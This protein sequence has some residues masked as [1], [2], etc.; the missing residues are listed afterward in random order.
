MASDISRLI[1]PGSSV[2]LTTE[3]DSTRAGRAEMRKLCEGLTF[4]DRSAKKICAERLEKDFFSLEGAKFCQGVGRN[5]DFCL[6]AVAN[7]RIDQKILDLCAKV[8]AEETY[9]YSSKSHCVNFFSKNTSSF[10]LAGVDFCLE[11][12]GR[13]FRRSRECLNAIRDRR[14]PH[15]TLGAC[16]GLSPHY[17]QNESFMECVDRVMNEAPVRKDLICGSTRL[18]GPSS[19]E[20]RAPETR[21]DRTGNR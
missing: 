18:P 11:N 15:D 9:H 14:V 2:A 8:K 10:D 19:G 5:L 17:G 1:G 20:A 4:V 7:R 12:N 13:D 21:S 16:R 3:D 6:P